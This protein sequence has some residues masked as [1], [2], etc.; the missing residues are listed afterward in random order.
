MMQ[1]TSPIRKKTFINSAVDYFKDN[2]FDS[3][4][5][6]VISSNFLWQNLNSPRPL[7]DHMNRPRRQDIHKNN[8]AYKE[9]GSFYMFKTDEFMDIKNRL[10]GKIGIFLTDDEE[11][12]DI[13]TQSDWDKAE[14]MLKYLLKDQNNYYHSQKCNTKYEEN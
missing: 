1:A 7:Y 4:L 5:S 10:F 13:D 2:N 6:A 12:I 14:L 3:M 8:L 11:G 9:T